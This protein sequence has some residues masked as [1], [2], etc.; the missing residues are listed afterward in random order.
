MKKN[1]T[2][3]KAELAR[4]RPL[5]IL[6]GMIVLTNA[7]AAGTGG[8]ENP[9]T[10]VLAVIFLILFV[11]IFVF[12]SAARRKSDAEDNGTLPTLLQQLK[13]QNASGEHSHDRLAQG[14]TAQNCEDDEL[15]HWKKQLDSFL[16]SGVID[17]S[18]YRTLLERY[19]K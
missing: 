5:L 7:V 15:L 19:K 10:L 8:V 13:Q 6:V 17:R 9:A 18:E 4:L 14:N 2:D 3:P 1:N 16:E 11:F 12:V